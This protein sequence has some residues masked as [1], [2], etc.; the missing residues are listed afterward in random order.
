MLSVKTN[1]PFG[2]GGFVVKC[3]FHIKVNLG[4]VNATE[5]CD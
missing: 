1:A 5:T 3:K 4:S 2:A